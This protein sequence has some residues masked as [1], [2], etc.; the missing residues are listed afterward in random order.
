MPH[1]LNESKNQSFKKTQGKLKEELNFE[2]KE[3]S[4]RVHSLVTKDNCIEYGHQPRLI[5]IE[6]FTVTRRLV[7][8][9]KYGGKGL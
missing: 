6:D 9:E 2:T 8:G 7:L 4:L 3:G 5:I 1:I